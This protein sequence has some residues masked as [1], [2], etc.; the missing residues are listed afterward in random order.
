M[1]GAASKGQG[2]NLTNASFQHHASSTCWSTREVYFALLPDAVKN[3]VSSF[4]I[5]TLVRGKKKKSVRNGE[6]K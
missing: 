1:L 4:C 2:R 5:H 3:I 6:F